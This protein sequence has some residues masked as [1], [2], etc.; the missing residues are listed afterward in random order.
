MPN[1][2][3][4]SLDSKITQILDADG[5]PWAMRIN[6]DTSLPGRATI[7][8]VGEI[9]ESGFPVFVTLP[10]GTTHVETLMLNGN[11]GPNLAAGANLISPVSVGFPANSTNI[12]FW[13]TS[14]TATGLKTAWSKRVLRQP[15]DEDVVIPPTTDRMTLS[16]NLTYTTT[17]A[18]G[19]AITVSARPTAS[20]TP[21]QTET[22]LRLYS[23]LT[24]GTLNSTVTP[25]PTTVPN[26]NTLFGVPVYRVHD[27]V[28]DEWIEVEGAA[29]FDIFTPTAS[30]TPVLQSELTITPSWKAGSTLNQQVTHTFLCTG[31]PHGSLLEARIDTERYT[32][33]WVP[34]IQQVAAN[35]WGFGVSAVPAGQPGAGRNAFEFY[36]MED[37]YKVK[38]RRRANAGV[39]WSAVSANLRFPWI[40]TG[41]ELEEFNSLPT[42][43][44]QINAAIVTGFAA[45]GPYV[46]GLTGDIDLGGGSINTSGSTKAGEP[47]IIKSVDYTNPVRLRGFTGR[48]FDF[49]QCN[50]FIISGVNPINDRTRSIGYPAGGVPMLN[51]PAGHGYMLE[52]CTR[53]YI[54]DSLI[55]DV[56]IGI[57]LRDCDDIYI[58]FDELDGIVQDGMRLYRRNGNIII[59]GE[60]QHDPNVYDALAVSD[61]KPNYHPDDIQTSCSMQTDWVRAAGT[62]MGGNRNIRRVRGRSYGVIRSGSRHTAGYWGATGLRDSGRDPGD[63]DMTTGGARHRNANWLWEDMYIVSTWNALPLAEAVD[64]LTMRRVVG[65]RGLPNAGRIPQLNLSLWATDVVIDN[66]VA[67]GGTYSTA[68]SA[69]RVADG[70]MTQ[71]EMAAEVTNLNGGWNVST[72]GWP[73]GWTGGET[74][75]P[76]G[77]NAYRV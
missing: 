26:N 54:V 51:Y 52:G 25:I 10:I 9:S 77:P 68:T 17:G 64:G 48:C 27:P 66:C 61:F 37:R 2:V 11:V 4:M 5:A 16:G 19:A 49:N 50:N 8:V 45:T 41:A 15:I 42:T 53:A 58:G 34:C 21:D 6:D 22:I 39:A 59:E 28:Y 13:H 74:R 24:D 14:V 12:A 72:T 40:T 33:G 73:T 70:W 29:R 46:I 43:L 35:V 57:E 23:A 75:F 71:A 38:F 65:R 3:I 36:D 44:A 63:T 7:L 62:R 47:L 30:P 31:S 32:T 76:T 55:A 1:E 67:A 56:D 18:V 60:Y 69:T 20:R